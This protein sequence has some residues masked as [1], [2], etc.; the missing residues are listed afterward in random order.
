MFS[1]IPV[2]SKLI[3]FLHGCMQEAEKASQVFSIEVNEVEGNAA[4][5]FI[6]PRYSTSY[7]FYDKYRSM[8]PIP[9]S[10]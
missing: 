5:F 4:K 9:V 1:T 10:I 3:T 7:L 2:Y 8:Q 6:V